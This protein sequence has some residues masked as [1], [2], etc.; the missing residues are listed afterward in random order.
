MAELDYGEYLRNKLLGSVGQTVVETGLGAAANALG[1]G[2]SGLSLSNLGGGALDVGTALLGSL[3]SLVAGET[4]PALSWMGGNLSSLGGQ[5]LSQALGIGT[6]GLL[7]PAF[8]VGV[9]GVVPMVGGDVASQL[10]STLGA[11]AGLGMVLPM[12]AGW[13]GGM[14]TAEE[15]PSWYAPIGNILNMIPGLGGFLS[16]F[17]AMGGSGPSWT[18]PDEY[19]EFYQK[20]IDRVTAMRNAGM[21]DYDIY[22][23]AVKNGYS[24]DLG[25]TSMTGPI[26][27]SG[28]Y[29]DTPGWTDYSIG[30]IMTPQERQYMIDVETAVGNPGADPSYG[31]SEYYGPLAGSGWDLTNAMGNAIDA[32]A[33]MGLDTKTYFDSGLARGPN[34]MPISYDEY[35]KY[36]PYLDNTRGWTDVINAKIDPS[37][38][39]GSPLGPDANTVIPSIYGGPGYYYDTP[40]MY[41][42][43]P[44]LAAQTVDP[45]GTWLEWAKAQPGSSYINLDPMLWGEATNRGISLTDQAALD[46]YKTGTP[47]ASAGPTPEQEA[48]LRGLKSSQFNL[49]SVTQPNN[50]I[51]K[52]LREDYTKNKDTEYGMKPIAQDT[53]LSKS[54]WD[55]NSK[56]AWDEK[57]RNLAKELI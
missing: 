30:G 29:Y 49:E 16:G 12:A 8:T 48:A 32:A 44:S 26:V 40:G 39:Q 5:Y 52:A 13:A 53:T 57:Q 37:R 14:G 4:N 21:S 43:L 34:G 27:N 42:W 25:G 55:T 18:Y 41:E 56:A 23:W 3:P 19:W 45:Y 46:A 24:V 6:G 11:T 38:L 54:V 2:G 17:F 36:K 35:L 47:V 10:G 22:N 7:N 15:A 33:S 28:V 1:L 51:S 31:M 9:N 50:A 20:S